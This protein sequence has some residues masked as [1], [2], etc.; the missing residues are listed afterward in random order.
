PPIGEQPVEQGIDLYWND[1]TAPAVLTIGQVLGTVPTLGTPFSIPI[2]ASTPIAAK[3][4]ESVSRF[5]I[6]RAV[7][8]SVLAG[9]S[10]HPLTAAT[11]PFRYAISVPPLEAVQGQML[12]RFHEDLAGTLVDGNLMKVR[13]ELGKLRSR[14]KEA[15]KYLFGEEKPKGEGKD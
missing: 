8:S 5:A 13:E 6:A 4:A 3:G 10:P 7:G 1:K 14:P 12:E 9:A 11:L 2:A 15:K